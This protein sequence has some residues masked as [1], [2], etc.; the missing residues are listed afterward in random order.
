MIKS[1]DIVILLLLLNVTS[2]CVSYTD[3]LY[4]RGEAPTRQIDSTILSVN[5]FAPLKI[6]KNDILSITI[7]SFEQKLALPYNIAA[8]ENG[9]TQTI[10]ATTT[11]QVDE[12]GFVDLPVL[13]K[14]NLEGKTINQAKDTL[15]TILKSDLE[16]PS[17]NMRLMNFRISVLGEVNK[18]GTFPITSDRITLLEAIALAEDLTP[19][20][21]AQNIFVIREQDGNRTFGEINLQSTSF[22]SSEFYYLRQGDVIYV[23]PRKDKQAVIKDNAAEYATLIVA[24][25]QAILGIA[26][27]I[28]ITN[29]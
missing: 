26:T 20:A 21:N 11:Y 4:F 14:I 19:Y 28:I 15:K 25:V 8:D 3:L 5:N 29:Q 2:S 12:D 27:I 7:R 1:R 16:D 9:L 13:G 6:Q 22:I 24:G 17:I 10:S 18:P 23:E